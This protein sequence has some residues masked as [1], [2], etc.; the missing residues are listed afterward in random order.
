MLATVGTLPL[1][2]ALF[3]SSRFGGPYY[4]T[5]QGSALTPVIVVF[6]AVGVIG[7]GLILRAEWRARDPSALPPSRRPQ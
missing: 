2:F 5:G 3:E 7:W 4:S 6:G 1:A